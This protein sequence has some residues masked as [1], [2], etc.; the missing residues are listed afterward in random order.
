M[1]N[2]EFEQWAYPAYS[3]EKRKDGN[4][5]SNETRV[6]CA[7]YKS[8]QPEIDV[9]KTRA[10]HHRDSHLAALEENAA[11]KAEVQGYRD[12]GA[13]DNREIQRLD[14][15]VDRLMKDAERLDMLERFELRVRYGREEEDVF[16]VYKV[17]GFPND[18]EHTEIG[19]GATVREAIDAAMKERK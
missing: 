13:A 2:E 6:A 9:L 16:F 8:R 5:K 12:R 14:A 3:L 15:E 4:Y 17:T 11:L 10:A 7:G 19:R 1:N 18:L